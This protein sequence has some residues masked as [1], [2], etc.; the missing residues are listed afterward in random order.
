[1]DIE[2]TAFTAYLRKLIVNEFK[3]RRFFCKK[4]LHLFKKT[5]YCII[6][7]RYRLSLLY[8]WRCKQS[9]ESRNVTSQSVVKDVSA[10]SYTLEC[11]YCLSKRED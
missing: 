6:T 7:V 1:M 9:E 2:I 3:K 4:H 5:L 8:K 11:D 10:K